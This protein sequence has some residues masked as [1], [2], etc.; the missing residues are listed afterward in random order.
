RADLLE[1]RGDP[2][3][4]IACL[5]HVEDLALAVEHAID[6]GQVR[7]RGYGLRK[8]ARLAWQRLLRNRLFGC[9]GSAMAHMGWEL[10]HGWMSAGTRRLRSPGDREGLRT[11]R[12]VRPSGVRI[13]ATAP[14]S[15]GS[16]L[17]RV[18][19]KAAFLHINEVKWRPFYRNR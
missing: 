5:T 18:P 13:I 3:L 11:V 8:I 12:G 14:T 10:G 1:V 2:L 15:N 6:T 4:E 9:P 7:Q 19:D 17:S 16:S